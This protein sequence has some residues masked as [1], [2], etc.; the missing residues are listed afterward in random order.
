MLD[1][2]ISHP[3]KPNVRWVPRLQH[4]IYYVA[5][6]VANVTLGD[7]KLDICSCLILKSSDV[8]QVVLPFMNDENSLLNQPILLGNARKYTLLR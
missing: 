6:H 3:T 7:P 8:V 5:P 4:H 1:L 2:M